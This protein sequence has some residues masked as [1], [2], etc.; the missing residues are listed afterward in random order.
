MKKSLIPIVCFI[1]AVVGC[2]KINIINTSDLSPLG[3]KENDFLGLQEDFGEEYSKF[4][5][6][7]ANV[8]IYIDEDKD[9]AKVSLGS[10]DLRLTKDNPFINI[11]KPVFSYIDTTIENI[12]DKFDE[13]TENKSDENINAK[14]TDNIEKD[15]ESYED[16]ENID[17]IVDDFI[18]NL[19]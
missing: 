11:V 12:K 18:K 19:E 2:I 7:K 13:N 1:I 3:N 15:N 16:K 5:E 8:K 9:S 6:D 10:S 4:M 17:I 14:D